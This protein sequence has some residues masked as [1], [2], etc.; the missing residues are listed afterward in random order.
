M[1]VHFTESVRAI[2]ESKAMLGVGVGTATFPRWINF[3]NSSAF[4][5]I[6]VFIGVIMTLT[7]ILINVQTIIHRHKKRKE[8]ARESEYRRSHN[9]LNLEILEKKARESKFKR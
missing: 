7:V 2:S 8:E 1:N 6:I 5:S 4:Q 3:I 9:A